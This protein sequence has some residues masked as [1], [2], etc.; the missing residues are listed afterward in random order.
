L[1]EQTLEHLYRHEGFVAGT[2]PVGEQRTGIARLLMPI[3]AVVN[4]FGRIVP[5]TSMIRALA[6]AGQTPALTS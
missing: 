6:A 4:P 2:L 3:L 1:F 5:P